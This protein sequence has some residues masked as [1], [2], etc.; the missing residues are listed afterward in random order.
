MPCDLVAIQAQVS[1]PMQALLEQKKRGWSINYFVNLEAE[2]HF[3]KLS[4][5]SLV[6]PKEGGVNVF[7]PISN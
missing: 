2:C 7:Y 6:S 3:P 1:F 4:V 5:A